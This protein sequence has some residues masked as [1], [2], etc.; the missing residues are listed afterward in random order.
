MMCRYTSHQYKTQIVG[1]ALELGIADLNAT[2]KS[3]VHVT[4]KLSA[5]PLYEVYAL[6][7][8]TIAEMKAMKGAMVKKVRAS[9]KTVNKK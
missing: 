8:V 3:V 5:L 1:E 6:Q 2:T 7:N 9:Y 4:I